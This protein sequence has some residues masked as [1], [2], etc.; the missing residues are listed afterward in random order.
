MK[1][2]GE[3]STDVILMAD[4]MYLHKSTQYHGGS[5]VGADEN[6]ELYKGVVVFMISGLKETANSHQS[7]PRNIY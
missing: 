3:L 5:Y 6:G 4:E 2:K 7:C 1:N